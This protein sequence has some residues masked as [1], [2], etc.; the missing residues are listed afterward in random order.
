VSSELCD[1]FQLKWRKHIR[2]EEKRKYTSV[3]PTRVRATLPREYHTVLFHPHGIPAI[4]IPVQASKE[5]Y[6][7]N[8]M[9]TEK[10]EVQMVSSV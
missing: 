10:E 1:L 2:N 8:C 6:Y 3:C 9:K 4:P 7:C 5:S